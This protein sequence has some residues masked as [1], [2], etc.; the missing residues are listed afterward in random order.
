MRMASFVFAETCQTPN[1]TEG[2]LLIK[3]L[4]SAVNPDGIRV[5]QLLGCRSRVLGNDFCGRILEGSDV[6][7]A[8]FKTA[9]IETGYTI[10]NTDRPIRYG[11]HQSYI[12]TPPTGI[13]KVPEHVLTLLHSPPSFKLPTT[14]FSIV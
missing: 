12:S 14:P 3:A 2:E 5:V 9:D 13:F 1:L 4:F 8:A 7:D 6:T 10:A 11:S